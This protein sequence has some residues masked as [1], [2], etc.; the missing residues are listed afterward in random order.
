M[1][2]KLI[3]KLSI[4]YILTRLTHNPIMVSSFSTCTS[5]NKIVSKK[6]IN[7]EKN[8]FAEELLVL[9]GLLQLCCMVL[10]QQSMKMV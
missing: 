7:L 4:T 1:T 10:V 3:L 9:V 5:I 6:L 2:N 8:K